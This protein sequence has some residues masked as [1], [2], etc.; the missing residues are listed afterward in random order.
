MRCGAAGGRTSEA[1]PGAPPPAAVVVDAA[2]AATYDWLYSSVPA[3]IGSLDSVAAL[4]SR[5]ARSE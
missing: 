1:D 5:K 3:L 4:F 2:L